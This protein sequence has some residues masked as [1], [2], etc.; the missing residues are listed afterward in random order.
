MGW[1]NA[2]YMGKTRTSCPWISQHEELNGGVGPEQL[3]LI[4]E[5]LA[6]AAETKDR[7]VALAHAPLLP[8]VTYYQDAVCWNGPEVSAVL[9]SFGPAVVPAVI[10]GHDHYGK[11][12]FSAKGIYHRVLDGALEGALNTPTHAVLE[13]RDNGLF[14]TWCWRRSVMG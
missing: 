3:H 14:T 5:R 4:K 9:D 1:Y 12:W 11:D 13:L 10:T 7:V 6:S 2:E 8:D